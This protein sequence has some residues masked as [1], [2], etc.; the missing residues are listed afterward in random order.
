[1]KNPITKRQKQL[2]DIIYR[3]IEN[4][5]YPPTLEEMRKNLGV[6]SN[7]SVL[8]LLYNLEKRQ[9]IKKNEGAARGITILPLGYEV[10]NEE[11]LVPAVGTTSAG[12]FMEAIE[13]TGQWQQMSG[14]V[15]RLQSDVYILKISG[16]SM[17][18]AG[19]ND[20]DLVLVQ[21]QNEFYSGDVVVA[22]IPEGTTVKRFISDDKPPYV[23]LKPENP[24]YQNIRFSED[25]R[26]EGKV[27]GIL[28][29]SKVAPIK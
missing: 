13:I 19:I 22:Q 25:M 18:N 3:F 20:G 26:M 14:E 4:T 23:Y 24:A 1:M 17:I 27:I 5:G 2:L 29:N 8:D 12:Q 11:P 6:S 7:Q 15:A 28:R 10:L 16:D 9:V 21:K